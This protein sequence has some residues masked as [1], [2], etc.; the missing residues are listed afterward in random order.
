MSLS[1]L[2]KNSSELLYTLIKKVTLT[3]WMGGEFECMYGERMNVCINIYIAEFLRCSP[4]TI[5]MLLIFYTAIQNFKNRF[6]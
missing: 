3:A 5:T 2:N 4:E 6:S 1:P